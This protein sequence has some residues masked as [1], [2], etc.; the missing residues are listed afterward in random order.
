[1]NATE[2]FC[3]LQLEDFQTKQLASCSCF[4]SIGVFLVDKIIKI[5]SPQVSFVLDFVQKRKTNSNYYLVEQLTAL[6]NAFARRFSSLWA[7]DSESF[8]K[9]RANVGKSNMFAITEG[10]KIFNQSSGP[11]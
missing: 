2:R 1:M 5:F 11:I 4:L 7:S 6:Q 8:G 9:N 10:H 3:L